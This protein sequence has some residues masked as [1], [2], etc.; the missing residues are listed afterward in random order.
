MKHL[1]LRLAK[2]K[3]NISKAKFNVHITSTTVHHQQHCPTALCVLAYHCVHGT[4]PSYR[5]DSLRPTSD[6]I[7]RRLRSVDS[8]NCWCRQLVGQLSATARFLWL[9]R[10]HGIMGGATAGWWNSLPAKTRTTS[11]LTTFRRQTK[12]YLFV[13]HSADGSL[14]V[15][16]AGGELNF[17]TCFCFNVLICV[18]C[19]RNFLWLASP[20]SWHL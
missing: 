7:A 4:A 18:R 9:Q 14:S 2:V 20:K 19:P 15:L 11:S 3:I 8:W 1:R 13:S 6:V 10:G 12:A 5:A 17:N 16:P